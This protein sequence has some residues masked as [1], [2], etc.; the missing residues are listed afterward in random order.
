MGIIGILFVIFTVAGF[1]FHFLA[2]WP[3]PAPP[4]TGRVAWGCWLL[5]SLLWAFGKVGA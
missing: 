3:A 4:Y 1:L 5:A 2:T